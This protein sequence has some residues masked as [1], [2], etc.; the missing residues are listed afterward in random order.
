MTAMILSTV[1][2]RLLWAALVILGGVSAQAAEVKLRPIDEAMRDPTLLSFRN[3]LIQAVTRRDVD[4][5]VAQADPDIKLSFGGSRGREAF[6][7][8]LTGDGNWQGEAYWREL[9]VT[10]R[11]G[12]VFT[13]ADEFCTPYL[14]CVDIDPGCDCSGYDIA[15]VLKEGVRAFA[16]ADTGSL[17]VATLNHDVL[18]VF[19]LDHDWARVKLPAGGYG[20][21]ARS[22]V[23]LP[24]DYRAYFKRRNGV[25]RIRV[26]I[27]G[28]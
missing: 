20:F 14:A 9:D 3:A 19:E 23:R 11:L 18:Q 21:V 10:L 7:N 28:D 27:A 13:S 5:V 12:G 17:V 25:W 26:F 16:E 6:R 2:R 24:V 1:H 4:Y 22:D 15:A 8:R